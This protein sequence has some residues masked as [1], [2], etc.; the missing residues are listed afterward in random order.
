MNA[1]EINA[2]LCDRAEDVVRH[3]FPSAKRKGVEMTIGDISGSPGDSF[4]ICVAGARVGCW[5]E[6]AGGP[7]G[8]QIIGLWHEARNAGSKFSKTMQE[9][10]DW[11]GVAWTDSDDFYARKQAIAPKIRP[12]PS[13][14]LSDCEQGAKYLASRGISKEVWDRYEVAFGPVKFPQANDRELLSLVFP[15]KSAEG[16]L[17]MHKFIALERDEKGKKIVK[18]NYDARKS[19]FGKQVA[20]PDGGEIYI[21]EGEIDCLSLA[22]MGY[23]AVSVPFGAKIEEKNEKE[24][25]WIEND[26]DY[27][28]CFSRIYLCFDKDQSGQDAAKSIAKRLGYT[29]CYMVDMPSECNDINDALLKD[30][31]ADL[32]DNIESARTLDPAELRHSS[33]FREDVWNKFNPKSEQERGVPFFLLDM[34]WRIRPG[35]LTLW[36]G[37]SGSGKSEVL[38]QLMVYLR[39]VG[40]RCCIASFEMPAAHTLRNMTQQASSMSYFGPSSREEFDFVYTWLTENIWVV[41]KVG[42]FTY[43]ELIKIMA[44]AAS[45][46]RVNHFVVDSLLCCDIAE[47]DYGKQKAFVN[48]LRM[49][50]M[51]SQT[52]VNLVAHPRKQK[53]E[54]AGPGK[55]D[56]RGAGSLTDLPQNGITISR[57]AAKEEA[58]KKLRLQNLR[59][60]PELERTPDGFIEMWKQREN[61]ELPQRPLFFLGGC[62]QY[63]DTPQPAQRYAPAFVRTYTD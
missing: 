43:Q 33:D 34:K 17:Q 6:F 38:N 31:K 55:M 9:A 63:V 35:E 25:D 26:F 5:S 32:F 30:L 40:Q 19:L 62:R 11:L 14:P 23:P 28:E 54:K 2:M 49:F 36:T 1:T 24:N 16:E 7:K 10:C 37:F 3:L 45:R 22:E 52:H 29:R 27:L 12:Y 48:A 60:T 21:C 61:G 39:S 59:T 41:D 15:C 56:V 42:V 50:A 58:V 44:Y 51:E 53:D 4:S 46:Y 18:S 13:K 47:D 57:N 20:K 8:R